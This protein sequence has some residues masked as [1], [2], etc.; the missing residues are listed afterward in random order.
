LALVIV[1]NLIPLV[2]FVEFD[3]S[4]HTVV[5]F[6]MFN[7]TMVFASS[8]AV[9]C[10]LPRLLSANAQQE[11]VHAIVWAFITVCTAWVT[12]ICVALF[13]PPLLSFIFQ[14]P[15]LS[16]PAPEQSFW[17]LAVALLFAAPFGFA[18]NL[19]EQLQRVRTL[20]APPPMVSRSISTI[21]C[22]F[23]VQA[24]FG[25]FWLPLFTL[26][27][28]LDFKGDDG[29]LLAVVIVSASSLFVDIVAT[30]FPTEMPGFVREF[31]GRGRHW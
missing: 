18:G 27:L 13:T 20:E 1:R 4:A 10:A 15:A 17:W 28:M 19:R 8:T 14:V 3:W 6:G 7:L 24:A 9:D 26:P 5:I 31:V 23:F 25:F 21:V 30:F 22:M 29:S 16:F 11:R 12:V 2:G